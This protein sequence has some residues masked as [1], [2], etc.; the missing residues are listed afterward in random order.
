[1]SPRNRLEMGR[2]TAPEL[3]KG[4]LAS[5]KSMVWNLGTLVQEMLNRQTSTSTSPS[6]RFPLMQLKSKN[7]S[8]G[9]SWPQQ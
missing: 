5:D 1:M 2:F 9:S 7:K 6:G 8:S 3:G 4:G